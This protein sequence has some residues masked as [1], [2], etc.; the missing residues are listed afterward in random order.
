MIRTP[1]TPPVTRPSP[2][3]M[4]T[5]GRM[6]LVAAS[7]R[8][9]WFVALAA[10]TATLACSSAAS[11]S[12]G[13]IP[14]HGFLPDNRGWEMVSP[15]EKNATDVSAQRGPH[16]PSARASLSGDRI[17]FTSNTAFGDQPQS[18]SQL[19]YVASRQPGAWTTKG[20]LP[21][22]TVRPCGAYGLQGFSEDLSHGVLLAGDPPLTSDALPRNSN[23]YIRNND[24]GTYDLLTPTVRPCSDVPFFAAASADFGH[25]VF[26]DSYPLTSDAPAGVPNVYEQTGGSIRLVNILPDGSA[27]AGGAVTGSDGGSSSPA[28]ARYGNYVQNAV[29]DDGSRIFWADLSTHQLYVRLNGT[30]TVHVSASQ[31]SVPD[32]AGTQPAHWRDATPDGSI[33][34]FTSAEK[35]TDDATAGGSTDEDLYA[36]NVPAGTLTDLSVNANPG[37]TSFVLG[38]LGA[39]DDGAYVYFAANAGLLAGESPPDAATTNIYLSHNGTLRHVASV[40]SSVAYWDAEAGWVIGGN[41]PRTSQVTGDGR[42][43]LFATRASMLGYDSDAHLNFYR[44][45]AVSDTTSCVTCNTRAAKSTSDAITDL[46]GPF[47]PNFA[48]FVTRNLSSD[49]AR[50]FFSTAEGLVAEDT[51]GKADAY[52]WEAGNVR[53]LSSGRSADDSYFVDASA[54]GNDAFFVT[55]ESLASADID[56]NLDIYDARVGGGFLEPATPAPPCSGEGC[57]GQPA[58]R[59]DLPEPR[60]SVVA[61]GGDAVA[62][63]R[64]SYAI[65]RI[66][67]AQRIGLARTGRLTLAVA[68]NMAGKLSVSAKAR[69]RDK[70]AVVGRASKTALGAAK[71]RL[72]LRL[73]PAARAQ[74]ASSGSLDIFITVAFSTVPQAK[75]LAV[76]LRRVKT[77]R[78]S[79]RAAATSTRRA[80]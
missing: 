77:A 35:L 25:V 4:P 44:Y 22:L 48:A 63:K 55:R 50:V 10:M 40:G 37:Q 17:L 11:A 56:H 33:V 3:N 36:Y 9:Q 78:R 24:G 57:Q 65:S 20:A 66:S 64:G 5:R 29:S 13:D 21:P 67:R 62:G 53:L 72:T 2:G 59:P 31:R 68:V 70:T 14:G 30:T 47:G 39:S 19:Q 6:S 76:R 52:E 28:G 58:G 18:F 79:L 80:G 27:A 41:F 71:V 46:P 43:L 15:V 51:N 74:L 26:E 7:R 54:S 34:Y 60:S 45:D 32:P 16:A 8:R 61:G 38:L 75:K 12:P 69:V 49:G 73:T 1:N 23:L 42:V